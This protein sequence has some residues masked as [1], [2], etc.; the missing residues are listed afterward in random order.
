MKAEIVSI[1]DEMTSGQR[2]DTNSR[3]LSQQLA[4]LGVTTTRHTTIADDL[5]ENI[6]VFASAA[7]RA[8]LVIATGGLGPTLDDLTRYALAAA[9]DAPLELDQACLTHIEG[10]FAQRKRP[11]PERNNVQAMLPRGSLVI[12][13]QHG[14]APGIDLSVPRS[15]QAAS[16]IF[17]LPGVPA[18]MIEMWTNT[19]QPRILNMLGPERCPVMFHTIKM[20]GI[21]ESDVEVQLPD[22]M[23]RDRHPRVGI[24]VSRA[25]ISLRIVAQARTAAEFQELIAPTVAEIK[26]AM[27]NLIFGEGEDELEHAVLRQLRERSSNL[28]V[29]EIGP[30]ALLGNWLLSACQSEDMGRVRVLSFDSLPQAVKALQAMGVLELSPSQKP[31]PEQLPE[32][33]PALATSVR[34]LFRT[35]ISLAFGTYASG[36]QLL[37]VKPAANVDVAISGQDLPTDVRSR[38]I[39]GHPDILNDRVAKTALDA[40]RMSLLKNM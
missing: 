25:T 34:L 11:M 9:F 5:E 4:D 1:G 23:R 3:W 35:D 27:G 6:E 14:T 33:L 10:M 12:P 40:L 31:V 16:R 17:A 19:V 32:L 13:N 36:D 7:Q 26:A 37:G 18:E 2:L 21:G 29:L 28:A 8:D 30:C 22:L 38:T 24:T 39:I 20:F 15:G